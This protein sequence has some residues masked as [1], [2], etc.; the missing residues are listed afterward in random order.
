MNLLENIRLAPLT[1]FKVGGPARYFAEAR[2]EE[3]IIAG[4]RYARERELP[5]FVLGGGSNLV[6]ADAGWPGLVIRVAIEGVKELGGEKTSREFEVGAGVE[7]DS[8]VAKSVSA[9]LAGLETLSGIPGTVGGTPVQ[10]VGAYGQEVS[11]TITS[12]RVLDLEKLTIGELSNG[13]CGFSYRAS[14]FNSTQRGRYVVLKVRFSLTAAGEPRLAYA[15]LRRYFE[16]QLANNEMPTLQETHDAVRE[17]RRSKAMLIVPNDADCRSAGSF[18]KNPVVDPRKYEEVA[19]VAANEGPPPK[20]PAD[21]GKVKIPAAWL[22]ERAGFRKGYAQGAVGISKKHS[23][24]IINR[25]GA[26]AAEIMALKNAVQSG[27]RDKFGIEL[28]PEPVFVGFPNS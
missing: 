28:Q 9:N 11:E 3:E 14:I 2:T 8:F 21:N 6:V 27:V 15:D 24:A 22:V 7:W 13:E 10:N 18:F 4:V 12:V 5:L 23:L 25:G 26:T 19:R 20:F 17:I 16:K 1:T